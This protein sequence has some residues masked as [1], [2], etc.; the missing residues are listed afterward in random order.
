MGELNRLS[1]NSWLCIYFAYRQQL[2]D[3][4]IAI[5]PVIFMIHDFNTACNLAFHMFPPITDCQ[6]RRKLD[7]QPPELNRHHTSQWCPSPTPAWSFSS[8]AC[9]YSHPQWTG[10][11]CQQSYAQV[12]AGLLFARVL[13]QQGLLQVLPRL[14]VLGLMLGATQ[15]VG[16]SLLQHHDYKCTQRSATLWTGSQQTWPRSARGK[17]FVRI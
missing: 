4:N 9:L 10:G 16:Y 11:E 12:P 5:Q 6:I 17:H 8:W 13:Q 1:I 7:A 2:H 3:F 15:C 14:A